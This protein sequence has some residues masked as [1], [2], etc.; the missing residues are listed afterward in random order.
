MSG[1]REEAN[2]QPYLAVGLPMT[3]DIVVSPEGNFV[4]TS[5]TNGL[6]IWSFSEKTLKKKRET[7]VNVYQGLAVSDHGYMAAGHVVISY[8]EKKD[9]SLEPE[10]KNSNCAFLR[11]REFVVVNDVGVHR[12]DTSEDRWEG[13]TTEF[14]WPSPTEDAFNRRTTHEPVRYSITNGK[15]ICVC[16]NYLAQ[17]DLANEKKEMEYYIGNETLDSTRQREHGKEDY[18]IAIDSESTLSA[19]VTKDDDAQT[20]TVYWIQTGLAMST[21]R[22]KNDT[23]DLIVAMEFIKT[24]DYLLLLTVTKR[25]KAMLWYPHNLCQKPA[26]E[27]FGTPL[28]T[29][30][31]QEYVSL[32]EWRPKRTFAISGA[33]IIVKTDDVPKVICAVEDHIKNL[34]KSLFKYPLGAT[35]IRHLSLKKDPSRST[36]SV[37]RLETTDLETTDISGASLR[38]TV[39][40][41]SGLCAYRNLSLIT[42]INAQEFKYFGKMTHSKIWDNGDLVILTVRCLCIFY[43]SDNDTIELGYY[44]DNGMRPSS[45]LTYLFELTDISLDELMDDS[46]SNLFYT[47]LNDDDTLLPPPSFKSIWW[48]KRKAEES[49]DRPRAKLFKN[50]INLLITRDNLAKYGNILLAEA[51]EQRDEVAVESIIETCTNLFCDNSIVYIGF[52]QIVTDSLP[53]LCVH[54]PDKAAKYFSNIR[55]ILAPQCRAVHSLMLP[56]NRICAFACRTGNPSGLTK[57]SKFA[58]TLDIMNIFFERYSLKLAWRTAWQ[59]T[60]QLARILLRSN[61]SLSRL[62]LR[63]SALS[64]SIGKIDH[65]LESFWYRTK[66]CKRRS[67]LTLVVRLPNF[68]SYPRQYS[69]MKDFFFPA[70]SPF[71]KTV[72]SRTPELFR[73]WD[74]E[75]L[76]NFKWRTFGRYYY[77]LVC[78]KFIV[79][80]VCFI[81]A[82]SLTEDDSNSSTRQNLFLAVVVFAGWHLHL[83]VRQFIW[84]PIYYVF[85]PWNW[86]DCGAFSFPLATAVNYLQ[87]N[88]SPR[89]MT[90]VSIFLLWIKFLFLLR[91]FEYFGIYMT[92]IFGVIKQVFSFLVILGIMVIGFAHALFVLLKPESGTSWETPSSPDNS[93]PNDPWKLTE[94]L[95]TVLDNGTI[96]NGT[97]L[98]VEPDENTNVYTWFTTSLLG[99]YK[100]L[101]G[102]WSSVANWGPNENPLLVMM[103]VLFSFFVVI[104]LMNLFIGLLNNAINTYHEYVSY[105]AQKAEILAEIELFYLTP[106]QRRSEWFPSTVHFEVDTK[107]LRKVMTENIQA[108]PDYSSKLSKHSKKMLDILNI[109]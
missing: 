26:N 85:S 82:I 75:A 55:L 74:G 22:V 86:F 98:V 104:Y 53:E 35:H 41:H 102:D 73:T 25:G 88:N 49:S 36:I 11:S 16:G 29:I 60:L 95:T 63:S 103:T 7:G 12:Y 19:F 107:E 108:D 83:E 91:P 42:S 8:G 68:C 4:A 46:R 6:I 50:L 97:S 2:T 18:V 109:K 47:E 78:I 34:N 37:N 59:V 10:L 3:N 38:W 24:W 51:I 40:P 72:I 28:D 44:W 92:I 65:M 84:N 27:G 17:W 66:L 5:H 90:S 100:F 69:A 70:P 87:E 1:I 54:Y 21:I 23:D 52:L 81:T 31:L 93:D 48:H 99:A 62:L 30:N 58:N 67:T 14:D 39:D 77:I 20:L 32:T 94:S 9:P 57:R 15:L 43:L 80:A 13:K 33:K 56:F 101:V 45:I 89:W 64:A 96:V 79:F 61:T 76:I 71:V 105:L 106:N